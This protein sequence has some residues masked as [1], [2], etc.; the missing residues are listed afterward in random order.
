MVA[1]ACGSVNRAEDATLTAAVITVS[2]GAFFGTRVDTSGPALVERL[3]SSGF[4]VVSTQLVPDEPAQ[5][6]YALRFAAS[7]ARLV[8]TTGGTGLG[9]RDQTP[10]TVT[11]M[12]DYEVN[13]L[14]EQMRAVG[15]KS[16]EF[17]MTSRSL[18]G[19]IGG[20]LILVLPGSP[21]GAVESLDA[22]LGVIA[23]ALDLLAGKTAH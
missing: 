22:V 7:V 20:S 4:S 3:S 5:L 16:T 21:R 12:L 10:Q 2:D 13:G 19:V 1:R 9:P 6:R 17:A 15:V 11:E 14:G 18:G 8:C 23:H